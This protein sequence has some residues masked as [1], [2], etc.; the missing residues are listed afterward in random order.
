[1]DNQVKYKE[2]LLV[3]LFS[4]LTL[5]LATII[6]WIF[7][8]SPGAKQ[9]RTSLPQG[10]K[11]NIYTVPANSGIPKTA[12][13]YTGSQLL[14][15]N[16]GRQLETPRNTPDPQADLVQRAPA[17]DA[18][19]SAV[20][21][22]SIAVLDPDAVE[23][24]S[25][26]LPTRYI[27]GVGVVLFVLWLINFSEQTLSLLI[28]AALLAILSKPVS[29]FFQNRLRFSRGLAIILTY[30]LILVL[31]V[32][33]PLLVIPAMINGINAFLNYD[34]QLV[35]DRVSASLD[36]SAAQVSTIPIIGAQVSNTLAG[37]S[38]FVQGLLNSVPK[39]VQTD[40]TATIEQLGKTIGVLGGLVG[41]LI[42]AVLS[43]VFMF[44]ISLQISFASDQIRGWIVNPMPQRFQNEIGDLLGRIKK[45]W[46]SF[47]HGELALMVVMGIVTWLL[48]VVLGTPQALFLGI[49]AGLLEII[50][51]LGPVLA[52]I[53]AAFLA[54]MFGSSYFPTLNPW[55]FM[56]IVIL[57]YV[58]LQAIENQVLVP[59]ILGNAV[60]LPPL[61]VL[62]GV[63]IGGA[64]AG[65]AGIFLATPM[66]ASG[67]ELLSFIFD[68]ITS[69]SEI[70]PPDEE[71]ISVIDKV[72]GYLRRI[73][74]P[75]RQPKKDEQPAPS[76]S[77][78]E[79]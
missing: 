66:V 5:G 31:I 9:N 52:T 44:L 33:I 69:T 64:K 20:S 73:H 79:E 61:I 42:S 34:W 78:T 11:Q 43:L 57:G 75:N 50:P 27:A 8:L 13:A 45:V 54:L 18:G 60:S 22:K 70:L 24:T 77:K 40:P 51:S 59:K 25:W 58:L 28:F 53:P 46:E 55:V 36:Q 30:L 47:L 6:V 12:A 32:S 3:A 39:P 2:P 63:T 26:T 15:E 1:M 48:N 62:V 72:R 17:S 74:L 41:P 29:N 76:V 65:I 67:K 7:R 23:S 10:D 38:Q 56:L 16:R 4:A 49:I 21:E 37:L 14:V 68:K 35:F 19:P 71:Q